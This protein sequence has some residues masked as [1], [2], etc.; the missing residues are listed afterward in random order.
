[1]N[2]LIMITSKELA[3]SLCALTR[4]EQVAAQELKRIKDMH[5]NSVVQ[6]RTKHKQTK[7]AEAY[8]QDITNTK[9]ILTRNLHGSVDKYYLTV[10]S[11]EFGQ[12][13]FYLQDFVWD[14]DKNNKYVNN[15]LAKLDPNLI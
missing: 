8:L 5:T 11:R 7:Q 13:R 3:E 9:Q 10:T 12:I 2:K 15:L 6:V 4:L 1:M 14:I